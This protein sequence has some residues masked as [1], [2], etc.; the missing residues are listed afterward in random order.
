MSVLLCIIFLNLCYLFLGPLAVLAETSTNL[1]S[2]K[3]NGQET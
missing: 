3:K 2:M 1:P